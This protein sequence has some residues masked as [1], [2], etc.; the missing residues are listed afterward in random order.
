M[1]RPTNWKNDRCSLLIPLERVGVERRAIRTAMGLNRHV[2]RVEHLLDE[3][4]E[5]LASDAACVDALLVLELDVE[6]AEF[7]LLRLLGSTGCGTNRGICSPPDRH[8]QLAVGVTRLV[9][10]RMQLAVWK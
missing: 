9:G 3:L 4:V 2:V 10:A 1:M 8:L 6:L 7:D 5:P